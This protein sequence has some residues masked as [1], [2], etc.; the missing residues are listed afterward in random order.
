MYERNNFFSGWY[1]GTGGSIAPFLGLVCRFWAQVTVCAKCHIFC[2]FPPGSMIYSSCPKTSRKVDWL[3]TITPGCERVWEC[4]CVQAQ[5]TLWPYSRQSSYRWMKENF[6]SKWNYEYT[7]IYILIQ[8]IYHVSDYH[9]H[10][11]N[12]ISKTFVVW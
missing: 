10:I 12:G 7:E 8:I 9:I 4:V 2:V 11:Q 6:F 3:H 5:N 1:G